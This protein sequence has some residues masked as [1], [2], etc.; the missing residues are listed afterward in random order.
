M[1][2]VLEGFWRQEYLP[3]LPKEPGSLSL[4]APL[5]LYVTFVLVGA[6]D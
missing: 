3:E 2:L 6:S 1:F 4:L 5:Y